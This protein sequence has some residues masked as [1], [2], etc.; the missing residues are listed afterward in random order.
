MVLNFIPMFA[1]LGYQRIISYN[2]TSSAYEDL[3]IGVSNFIVYQWVLHQRHCEST[4]RAGCCWE[5]R[6]GNRK[7][8]RRAGK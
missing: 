5:R 7:L 2:R 8:V 4:A 3:S 1:G 6:V